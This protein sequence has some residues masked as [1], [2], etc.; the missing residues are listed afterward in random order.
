MLNTKTL[1]CETDANHFDRCILNT[2]ILEEEVVVV[3]RL[4]GWVR[5]EQINGKFGDW[6]LMFIYPLYEIK[7]LKNEFRKHFGNVAPLCS[8]FHR[9][10]RESLARL[11]RYLSR[12]EEFCLGICEE[13]EKNIEVIIIF[14]DKDGF[15]ASAIELEQEITKLRNLTR[16]MHLTH[17]ATAT[18]SDEASPVIDFTES[19]DTNTLPDISETSTKSNQ[20][21]TWESERKIKSRIST[22][23]EELRHTKK[24]IESVCKTVTEQFEI[25]G[26]RR[27]SDNVSSGR[28]P[29]FLS[30][31]F[32]LLNSIQF[33]T[34]GVMID[35]NSP[36]TEFRSRGAYDL[37][38]DQFLANKDKK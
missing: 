5:C 11:E 18:Q 14:E 19:E 13:S 9:W 10:K 29:Q 8:D 26:T 6:F 3:G 20:L 7:K 16:R 36:Q 17:N 1:I 34:M 23:S 4:A 31:S 12:E 22:D 28:Q 38:F 30:T 35:C 37:E 15:G 32:K 33:I 25:F 27:L 2:G 24:N 21:E